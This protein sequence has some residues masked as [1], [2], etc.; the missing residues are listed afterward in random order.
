MTEKGIV[1]FVLPTLT[2]GLLLGPGRAQ[3]VAETVVTSLAESGAGSLRQVLAEASAGDTLKFTATGTINLTAPIVVDKDLT[4]IADGVTLDA[5]GKGRVLE[6][7]PGA[8]VTVRGGTLT[9]GVGKAEDTPNSPQKV[10][11]GGVVINR[12]TL[13]LDSAT[14]SNGKANLGGGIYNAPNAVLT[15]RGK[16]VISN[17]T[18]TEFNDPNVASGAGGGIANAGTLNMEEGTLSNNVAAYYGGGIRNSSTGRM[19]I[20]GG[21]VTGNKCT[22]A[23]DLS[24]LDGCTGGGIHTNGEATITG[25]TFSGNSATL[26]AGALMLGPRSD[27]Q[28][29]E[30]T[31]SGGT[32]ENNSGSAMMSMG[33]MVISGGTFRHN[34]ATSGGVVNVFTKGSLEISGGLFE[35]NEASKFGGVLQVSKDAARV[36]ISGGVMRGNKAGANGGA[37]NSD[38]GLTLTGGSIEGNSAGDSGG[39]IVMNAPEGKRLVAEISGSVSIRGNSAK[40]FAGGLALFSANKEG[41]SLTVSMSGG[42]IS[43]NQAER[44]AGVQLGRTASLNLSGG[45]IEGN[46]ARI[47]GGGIGTSGTVTMTG[48]RVSG[49]STTSAADGEGKG[50]GVRVY[51]TGTLM[52]SGGQISG[53]TASIHGGGVFT[54]APDPQNGA[55]GGKFTLSG[56]TIEGNRAASGAGGGVLNN[57]IFLLQG[58][59]I[60]GNSASQKGGGVRNWKGVTFTQTGG[61]VE[62]NAPDNIQTD[63]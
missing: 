61:S 13:T 21:R 57:G 53:N 39:G 14:V 8:T 42:S 27:D 48:G 28:L 18:A 25:G 15:I 2:L 58:G 56:A 63:Q 54:S 33:R 38:L 22:Y 44:S 9:G 5:G 52:A 17:N 7:A 6:V 23:G 45:S 26:V 50:G 46:V 40:N 37:M 62:G 31:I 41:T 36:T 59:S 24:K 19:T 47:E 49:N 35:E 60:T 1:R 29:A 30:V 11:F 20:S 12:G 43:G 16:T 34:T 32:F 4:I 55:P 51:S 10:T 3:G